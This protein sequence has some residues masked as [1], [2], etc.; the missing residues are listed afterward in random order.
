MNIRVPSGIPALGR[1]ITALFRSL[2]EIRNFYNT[3]VH[4]HIPQL[5]ETRLQGWIRLLSKVGVHI[6]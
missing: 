6:E 2:L 4:F 3:K 5:R 1:Q